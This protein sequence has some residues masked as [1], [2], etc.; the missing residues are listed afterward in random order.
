MP[1]TLIICITVYMVMDIHFFC[2][3][4]RIASKG[5]VGCAIYGTSFAASDI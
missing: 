4:S 2:A 1:Q 5:I 3:D